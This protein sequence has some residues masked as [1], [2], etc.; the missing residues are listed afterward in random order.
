MRN[1]FWIIFLGFICVVAYPGVTLATDSDKNSLLD[2]VGSSP[3]ISAVH[4]TGT[5]R[6]LR[7]DNA[8]TTDGDDTANERRIGGAVADKL[9]SIALKITDKMY[10][11]AGKVVGGA[12]L[13]KL[14]TKAINRHFRSLYEKGFKPE[15]YYAVAAAEPKQAMRARITEAARQYDEYYKNKEVL[16]KIHAHA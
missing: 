1:L 11:A 14:R 12:R 2:S 5:A 4:S 7:Y 13:E 10:S 16:R 6:F 9:T 3:S 15:D 8:A